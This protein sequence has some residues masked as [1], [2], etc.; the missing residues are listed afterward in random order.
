MAKRLIND[1]ENGL[2]VVQD[3][4]PELMATLRLLSAKEVLVGVPE[5]NSERDDPE[6]KAHGITNA[7]LAYIHDNGAPEQ[8][9]PA[10]PFMI[11]GMTNAEPAVTKLLAKTGEY[12]LQGR[13]EKLDEGLARVGMEVVKSIQTVIRNGIAPPLALR[14]LQNRAAR[15]RKG[16]KYEISWR[17]NGGAPSMQWAIPLM[18]TNEMLKSL[19]YTI[20]DRRQ[21]KK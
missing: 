21:R 4:L 11:P 3:N 10:R 15:G 12:V 18:D 17:D 20:R 7:V 14:T 6:S 8:R 13:K 2:H 5:E 9:I 16:A 19:S 1:K